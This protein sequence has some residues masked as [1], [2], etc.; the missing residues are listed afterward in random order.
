MGMGL[1]VD[2]EIVDHR[3]LMAQAG[4][5]RFKVLM[6][7]EGDVDRVRSFSLLKTVTFL[8]GRAS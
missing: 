2:H 6:S 3:R 4:D 5:A 8:A 7:V 1:R